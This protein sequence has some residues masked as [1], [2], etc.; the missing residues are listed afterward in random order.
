VAHAGLVLVLLAALAVA[1]RSSSEID[2]TGAT[3]IVFLGLL[4]LLNAM[5]DF[6]S[7]GLTRWLLRRGA[8][9]LGF[10]ALGWA[11]GDLF[12]ALGFF[13]L[14]GLTLV[15]MVHWLN[16]LDAAPLLDLG[17]LFADIRADPGAY[18]WLYVSI[19]STLLP[20]LLHFVLA[21]FSA[22]LAVMRESV[23]LFIR[24][25]LPRIDEDALAK[26]AAF[27]TLSTIGFLAIAAVAFGLYG[28]VAGALAAF[29]YLGDWYLYGFELY[30][31]WLGAPV[32]PFWP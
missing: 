24:R 6:L 4:P 11:L 18:W 8:V 10:G 2:D 13:A 28:L 15:T 27:W 30:A 31:A 16:G 9:S 25:Q 3:L 7:I 32:R 26:A 22:L 29:P 21:S 5:F 19:F 12:S 20:T 23:A 1:V 17:A 14:L